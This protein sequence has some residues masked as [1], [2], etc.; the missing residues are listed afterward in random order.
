MKTCRDLIWEQLDLENSACLIFLD[1]EKHSIWN[2]PADVL[3]QVRMLEEQYD[4][5]CISIEVL[6]NVNCIDGGYFF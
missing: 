2:N 5:S 3:R 4:P 1:G 6:P